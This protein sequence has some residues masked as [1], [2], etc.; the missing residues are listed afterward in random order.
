MWV[1]NI[2]NQL[3]D[4]KLQVQQNGKVSAFLKRNAVK[5][6]ILGSLTFGSGLLMTGCEKKVTPKP[7]PGQVSDPEAGNLMWIN[8]EQ[9]ER[10]TKAE[11]LLKQEIAK[12][13]RKEDVEMVAKIYNLAFLYCDDIR[14]EIG[15]DREITSEILKG[16]RY[17]YKNCGEE[18]V[19]YTFFENWYDAHVAMGGAMYDFVTG[20]ICSAML[21]DCFKDKKSPSWYQKTK[22]D[23][24]ATLNTVPFM[25]LTSHDAMDRFIWVS[26]EDFIK[27]ISILSYEPLGKYYWDNTDTVEKRINEIYKLEH[28]L[29]K[30][31]LAPFDSPYEGKKDSRRIHY[32]LM[33]KY[34]TGKLPLSFLKVKNRCPD[35]FKQIDIDVKNDSKKLK[36]KLP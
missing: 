13:A 2:K 9:L 14:F 29:R 24:R 33:E 25:D 36:R 21:L 10:K 32:I 11:I 15:D 31:I 12:F 26:G 34:L 18:D 23:V 4:N 20:R 3:F 6:L 22:E 16:L 28:N 35:F 27:V 8:S 30:K 5:L 17:V 1:G 7:T 19:R